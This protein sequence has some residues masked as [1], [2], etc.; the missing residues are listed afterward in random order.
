MFEVAWLTE[1]CREWLTNKIE[2]ARS[3]REKIFLF[4]ECWSILDKCKDETMMDD[5]VSELAHEE[6][7]ALLS[8]YLSDVS[9]LKT[10]QIDLLLK[11]GGWSTGFFLRIILENLAGQK[12]LNSNLK[13]LLENLNLA[14]CSEVNEGLY[15]KVM[16]RISDL[17]KISVSDPRFIHQLTTRTMRRVSYR[18]E[19]LRPRTSELLAFNCQIV[20]PGWI[21]SFNVR[22][23]K[24]HAILYPMGRASHFNFGNVLRNVGEGKVTS[25]TPIIHGLIDFFRNETHTRADELRAFVSSLENL[26]DEKKLMKAPRKCLN[27]MIAAFKCSSHTNTDIFVTFLKEIKHNKKLCTTNEMVFLESHGKSISIRDTSRSFSKHGFILK[28]RYVFQHPLSIT[29]KRSDS[30]CGFIL[31]GEERISATLCTDAEDYINT[32]IHLHDIITTSDMFWYNT[33]KFKYKGK[34]F[35]VPDCLGSWFIDSSDWF[36]NEHYSIPDIEGGKYCVAYN[37]AGYV[38][39]K[40]DDK[41]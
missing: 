11:L 21:P 41:S 2:S 13:Y 25:M 4:K 31:K 17:T 19:R 35:T 14:L 12:A 28:F 1:K 20:Y 36:D 15:L 23:Q 30:K 5:L 8:Y 39:A 26:C 9:K 40:N 6:N 27:M 16:D 7:T 32:G 33:R 37:V 3:N 22:L 10:G 24:N 38:V 34:G 29:C 18:K